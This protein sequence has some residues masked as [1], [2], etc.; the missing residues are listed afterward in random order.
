M[1]G[2][3]ILVVGTLVRLKVRRKAFPFQFF[4][5]DDLPEDQSSLRLPL[6][7]FGNLHEPVG[8]YPTVVVGKC[9]DGR[10][11]LLHSHVAGRRS[12]TTGCANVSKA[13]IT[14]VDRKGLLGGVVVALVD[15]EELEVIAG[16]AQD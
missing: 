6:E 12:A 16:I 1:R 5:N 2:G 11:T 9:Y 3:K 13:A 14:S 4:G 10:G 7:E 15:D 8:R